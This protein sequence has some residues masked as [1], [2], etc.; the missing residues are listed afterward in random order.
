[1]VQQLTHG[2]EGHGNTPNNRNRCAATGA[3]TA[4]IARNAGG[5]RR[6]GL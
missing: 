2:Y 3:Q 1:M 4:R 5:Q 6:R